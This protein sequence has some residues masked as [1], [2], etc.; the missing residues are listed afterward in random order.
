MNNNIDSR[1]IKAIVFAFALI[2]AVFVFNSKVMNNITLKNNQN[3]V[4]AEEVP[5]PA[6]AGVP[7]GDLS[8]NYFS[9]AVTASGN[10]AI[11]QQMPVNV[12]IQSNPFTNIVK[13]AFDLYNANFNGMISF[14][15]VDSPTTAQINVTFPARLERAD[16]EQFVAGIT[17]N[18]S[19]G[20]NIQSSNIK[21]LT[22]KDG[23]K[24]SSA[25][26]YNT[27]LH[28]IG[29]ALGI[30]GHS[31]NRADIMYPQTQA[32][33]MMTLSARDMA[34][35]KIM[36]SKNT[37][38]INQNSATASTD[39]LQEALRY[40]QQAPNKTNS[41]INLGNVY[42]D[43]KMLP[44]ALEAYK[45]ALN[46]DP[47]DSNIY[48]S[49]AECYYTSKKYETS[50]QFYEYAKERTYDP[51]EIENYE[52]MIALSKLSGQK[53]EEAYNLYVSLVDKY[54]NKK[55][56]FINYL[57]LCTYLKKPEGKDKLIL[58]L[59]THPEAN[60]D[61]TIMQYKSYYKIP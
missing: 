14:N 43:L 57:Y 15:Y 21:L 56:Y 10:F 39:K 41:W 6:P 12:Y 26:V 9:N 48:A 36:Y 37:E 53:Y 60:N 19:S 18:F 33:T 46:I 5:V 1:Y 59:Q 31:N 51:V 38:L 55:E 11:W 28:E 49:M 30:N 27:A 50:A 22:Q 20:H 47:S 13:S 35:L 61:N 52:A 42:Y 29:H 45:K 23:I 44:E 40:T 17:N 2:V 25:F 54:P 24:F 4:Q 58:F 32:N 16:E 34:T 8:D 7:S 3:E